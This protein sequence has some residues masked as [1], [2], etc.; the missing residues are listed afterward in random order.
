M[1]ENPAVKF[2]AEI[3]KRRDNSLSTPLSLWSLIRIFGQGIFLDSIVSLIKQCSSL[4]KTA[5]SSSSLSLQ[6]RW[7]FVRS[8]LVIAVVSNHSMVFTQ[9]R[10]FDF[11]TT[12]YE[13]VLSVSTTTGN[14][15][16]ASKSIQ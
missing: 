9:E 10:Y 16:F 1:F 2:V 14:I 8:Y 3:T 4:D 13:L 7:M 5:C 11:R 6:A 12:L 15:L